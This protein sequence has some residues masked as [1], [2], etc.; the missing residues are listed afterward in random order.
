[1]IPAIIEFESEARK[2]HFQKRIPLS[3][4]LKTLIEKKNGGGR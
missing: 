1:M 2:W 3:S 4:E